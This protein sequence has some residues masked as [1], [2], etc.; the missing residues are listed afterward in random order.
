[1][2]IGSDL[3]RGRVM[4]FVAQILAVPLAAV[5]WVT[6]ATATGALL[7]A[8][9]GPVVLTVTGAIS[10]RNGPEGVAFDQAMLE[11]LGSRTIETS[12]IWTDGVQ[13]FRGVPLAWL[14]EALGA[15]GDRIQ[16]LAVT[17]F[18][19]TIPQEDWTEDGPIVAYERN[20]VRMTLRN[21]GPLWVIYPFDAN[22]DFRSEITYFRSVWQLNRIVV[23]D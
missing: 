12:T 6:A 11:A 13:E 14:M 22:P 23:V 3:H 7:P 4:S 16:A 15:R 10:Q 19:V 8:P 9:R 2:H 1:M 17:D 20:G 21:G 5:F 18:S